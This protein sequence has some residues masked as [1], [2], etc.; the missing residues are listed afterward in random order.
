MLARLQDISL[1]Q[2][3]HSLH[4]ISDQGEFQIK[5]AVPLKLA[6]QLALNRMR[7]GKSNKYAKDLYEKNYKVC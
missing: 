3:I 4:T 1:I 7:M 5:N 2:I 6:L